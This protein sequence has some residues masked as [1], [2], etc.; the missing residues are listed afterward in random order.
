V[1]VRH[2]LTEYFDV[3]VEEETDASAT[4]NAFVLTLGQTLHCTAD[5]LGP[6]PLH[7]RTVSFGVATRAWRLLQ[8]VV[9]ARETADQ[10]NFML[11]DVETTTEHPDHAEI[12]E[13]GV[14]PFA[15]GMSAETPTTGMVRPSG[16]GVIDPRATD[17]RGLRWIDVAD[18]PGPREAGLGMLAI[19]EESVAVGHN[20]E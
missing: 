18:A 17:V 9:M 20:I 1:I 6:G 16:P 7:T 4:S 3:S 5:G 11:L 8:L 14:A 13:D 12:L 10:V 15:D 19:L 2:A